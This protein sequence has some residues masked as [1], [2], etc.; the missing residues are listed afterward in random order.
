MKKY[1]VLLLKIFKDIY[2]TIL[3]IGIIIKRYKKS[4]YS[5]YIDKAKCEVVINKR[6]KFIFHHTLKAAINID[7]L[8]LFVIKQLN[9]SS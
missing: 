7:Y 1:F 3:P 2:R 8:G 5:I 4:K 6:L 9:V